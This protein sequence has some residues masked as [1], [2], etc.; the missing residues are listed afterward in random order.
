MATPCFSAH[1]ISFSLMYSGPLST[2]MVPGLPRHSMIRS[3][4]EEG[5]KTIWEIAFPTI[6]MTRSA[7]SEKSTSIP[8]PFAVDVV[9]HVQQPKC[10]TITEA[11]RHEVHGPGHVGGAVR[12]AIDPGD[13]L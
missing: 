1:F 8:K 13:R 9:E 6:G 12:E 10:A 4:Y 5:Q 2:R 7:G 11:I 3:R